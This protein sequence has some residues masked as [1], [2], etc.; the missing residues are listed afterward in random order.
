VIKRSGTTGPPPT[1][2]PP[3]RIARREGRAPLK[4]GQ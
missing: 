2:G 4:A 3:T 1:N